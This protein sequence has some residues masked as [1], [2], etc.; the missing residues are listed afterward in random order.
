MCGRFSLAKDIEELRTEFPFIDEGFEDIVLK[1]RFNI[2][3]SQIC[4]V[5]INDKGTVKIKMFSWGL[6]PYWAKDRNI[7]YKMINARSETVDE[8]PSYK[9]P[10]Q[11]RRCLVPADGFFEWKKEGKSGKTP[12]R[13]IM[14]D[15][16][17][18]T[19]AGLWEKWEKEDKPLYS[20]TILTCGPNDIMEPVHD[21][22]PVILPETNREIWLN[23]EANKDELKE[24]LVPHDPSK[25][26]IYRVSNIVNSWKNDVPEC[27]EPF[28]DSS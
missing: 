21:R 22:M 6:V 3:P 16:K 27:I 4:P 13:F 24:L 17:P 28:D 11:T 9:K 2:A 26:E 10:F 12:Y 15:K 14:K 1:P 7:G 25:M 19:F 20:F 23:E 8:K 18:F 5:I